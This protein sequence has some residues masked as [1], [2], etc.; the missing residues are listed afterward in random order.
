LVTPFWVAVGR[1]GSANRCRCKVNEPI[2]AGFVGQL[3]GFVVEVVPVLALNTCQ[4]AVCD[5]VAFLAVGRACLAAV[6]VSVGDSGSGFTF[7]SGGTMAKSIDPF[8]ARRATLTDGVG[9]I[10]I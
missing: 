5:V 6:L 2:E 1:T 3:A 4:L 8:V 9:Q 7:Q 10:L